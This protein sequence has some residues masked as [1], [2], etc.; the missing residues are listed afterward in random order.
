MDSRQM[1]HERNDRRRVRFVGDDDPWVPIPAWQEAAFFALALGG[2]AG[3]VT[4]IV[5]WVL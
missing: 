2:F 5:G 1:R 3:L 4:L